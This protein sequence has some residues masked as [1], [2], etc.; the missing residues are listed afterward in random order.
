MGWASG[1]RLFDRI[2]DGL[3]SDEPV[4]KKEIIKEIIDAFEEMDWDTQGGSA[5]FDHPLIQEV[6]RELHPDWFEDDQP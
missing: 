3:L 5:Y 1:V 2:M 6:M 4:D